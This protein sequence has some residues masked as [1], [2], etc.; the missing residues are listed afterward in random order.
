MTLT[1][2]LLEISNIP[3]LY[4]KKILI[5]VRHNREK[6]AKQNKKDNEKKNYHSPSQKT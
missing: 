1:Q 2:I 5:P 4:I 6:T 3:Y